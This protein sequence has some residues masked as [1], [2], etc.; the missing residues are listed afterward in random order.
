VSMMSSSSCMCRD[1]FWCPPSV[2]VA[3]D[4]TMAVDAPSP[5]PSTSSGGETIVIGAGRCDGAK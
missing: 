5:S 3:G 1:I 4:C 2:A